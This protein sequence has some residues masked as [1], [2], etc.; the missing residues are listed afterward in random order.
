MLKIGITGQA[1]FVGNHL[2][3]TIGLFPEEFARVEFQKEYFEDTDKLNE[4]VAQCDVIVHLA[5]MNRHTDPNVIYDTNVNLVQKLI[6]SLKATN[7]NAHVLF[8]SSTQEERDNLYG[9]SKK[10]GRELMVE[11][12]ENSKGR[13]TGMIIP[14]VFGPFGQPNYNSV[15]AT[16]CHKLSHN[17]I[18]V[19]EVDG[20]L[21]LIYVGELVNNIISEIRT[22]KGN[23]E[24]LIPHTSESTVSG[25]LSL[26]ENYKSEYLEKGIVP[27]INNVFELNLFNTFRSYM[28]IKNHFPVK[29]TQHTDARGSFVEIIRLGV[30]GQVS[31]S[32]TH[33]GITRGNHFHTRKIERFAVIKGKALIQLRRVGFDE[34]IDFYLDG[35]EPSYVDMPIWYTHN[36]KNIGD[37]VLYTNFWINEFF[38]PND[39]DTYFLDVC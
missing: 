25:I 36:I 12:T 9:K 19:I 29:F 18:P 28:D 17:E 1:G 10:E 35:N 26:L 30:G 13:F 27:S 21:K 20:N 6:S 8:S 7:S 33:P 22:R 15:I 14:N 11:W 39:P 31:F 3:N 37:E 34:V 23:S 24:I 5:A 2:Y 4:F 16:F 32:T 38:D